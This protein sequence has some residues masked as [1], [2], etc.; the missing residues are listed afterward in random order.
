MVFVREIDCRSAFAVVG[1]RV[2]NIDI[3]V[4]GIE[5]R[6]AHQVRDKRGQQEIDGKYQAISIFVK[7]SCHT[8]YKP[9]ES[10]K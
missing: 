5:A 3:I 6:I 1:R 7:T 9:P 8:S 10:D 2:L 4:L